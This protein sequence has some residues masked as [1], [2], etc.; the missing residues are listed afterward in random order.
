V[1]FSN[2]S[3]STTLHSPPTTKSSSKDHPDE[4]QIHIHEQSPPGSYASYQTPRQQRLARHPNPHLYPE[5]QAQTALAPSAAGR[6]IVRKTAYGIIEQRRRSQTNKEFGVLKD[7]IPVCEG[8]EMNKLTRLQ[9][10]IEDVRYLEGRVSQ[11]KP[12][13]EEKWREMSRMEI[14]DDKDGDEEA[15][16][17]EHPTDHPVTSDSTITLHPRASGPYETHASLRSPHIAALP[18]F[19]QIPKRSLAK[20][21]D[22][23]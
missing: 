2:E 7:M 11:I 6:E 19:H 22:P 15:D 10:G 5:F 9:A 1:A 8:M 23:A 12:E 18:T 16:E 3:S 14:E 20:H 13:N 4:T 17:E 21:R